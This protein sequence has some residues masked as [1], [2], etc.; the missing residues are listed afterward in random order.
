MTCAPDRRKVLELA[1]TAVSREVAETSAAQALGVSQRT[2]RRWKQTPGGDRRPH[3]ARPRPA[4][5]LEPEEEER[6]VEVCGSPEFASKPPGEIVPALADRGEYVASERTF[7]RVLHRH[8]QAAHRG[9]FYRLYIVLDLFSRKIVAWEIWE[10]ENAAHSECLLRRAALSENIAAL[11]GLVLHGDNG[12]PLK[13]GT[14]LALMRLLGITPSHSRPRVS[15]D[16]AHAE[17]FFRTA[18]YHPSLPPEGFASLEE[19]RVWAANFIRWYNEEHLH[20]SIGWVTPSQKHEGRDLAI[21]AQRRVVYEKAKARHPRRWTSG[22]C[23]K[24][25]PVTST[26]LNP[27]S[28]TILERELEKSA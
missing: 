10:T 12:S 22:S 16:N 17:A 19:A 6:I 27:V 21:L 18:K 15:N 9:L 2:L 5:A 8:G 11:P 28:P 3:A 1:E 4:H 23:R 26:T 25:R 13:A 24:W 7:Y 14:V 20:A